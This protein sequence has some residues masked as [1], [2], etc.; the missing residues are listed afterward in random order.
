[1]NYKYKIGHIE[2]DSGWI[3]IDYENAIYDV[4]GF[5]ELVKKIF[6]NCNGKIIEVGEMRYEIIGAELKLIYQYDDL[7]GMVVEYSN[8]CAKE[9][10]ISFIKK[11]I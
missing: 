7:F 11:Y 9:D 4:N 1:M 2:E 10:A 5:V 3:F 8:R 6:E